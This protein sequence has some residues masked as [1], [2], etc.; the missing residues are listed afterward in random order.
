M[1]ED[2]GHI[3]SASGHAVLFES[4]GDTTRYVPLTGTLDRDGYPILDGI[5]VGQTVEAIKFGQAHPEWG[6][7]RQAVPCRALIDT[8]AQGCTMIPALVGRLDLK[9]VPGTVIVRVRQ[10]MV[11]GSSGDFELAYPVGITMGGAFYLQ[12]N[13]PPIL[14]PDRNDNDEDR[15][16]I[17]IG[18]DVLKRCVLV[19]DGPIGKTFTL[20]VPRNIHPGNSA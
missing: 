18:C 3:L 5:Y 10:Q 7:C 4:L 16:E 15:Y 17:L 11:D 14:V 2:T 6:S 12:V 8:G 13:V 1:A 20:Y 9:P 19:Y